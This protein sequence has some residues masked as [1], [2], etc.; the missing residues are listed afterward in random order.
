MRPRA[1]WLAAGAIVA[2]GAA[3]VGLVVAATSSSS[4]APRPA[5]LLAPEPVE[6][7]RGGVPSPSPLAQAGAARADAPPAPALPSPAPALEAAAPRAVQLP[8]RALAELT[9]PVARCLRGGG[10]G[11]TGPT[12]LALQL[13]AFAGGAEVTGAEV[14]S[15]G[16]ADP[17]LIACARDAVQGARLDAPG[18]AP[19]ELLD[20]TW[21]VGAGPA[22][23]SAGPAPS[24]AAAPAPHGPPRAFRRQRGK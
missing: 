1:P 9:A 21:E 12:V 22:P 18:F 14:A 19:G 2:L 7:D 24:G 4:S 23:A 15:D 5:P 17:S 6:Q 10:L 16:G 8:P 11:G 3:A 13:R 20:T